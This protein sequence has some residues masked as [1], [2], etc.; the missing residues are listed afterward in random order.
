MNG[1]TRATLSNDETGI[2]H[3]GKVVWEFVGVQSYT[4]WHQA[5]SREIENTW[6]CI[7]FCRT[8]G[9]VKRVQE[10]SEHSVHIRKKYVVV[11]SMTLC[12]LGAVWYANTLQFWKWSP[13]KETAEVIVLNQCI[14]A[15][16]ATG[17]WVARTKSYLYIMI[18]CILFCVHSSSHYLREWI[19]LYEVST[20]SMNVWFMHRWVAP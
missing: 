1:W 6:L 8:L 16:S 3:I 11:I 20:S 19:N 13:R 7:N 9:T 18:F 5:W 15:C 14:P 10:V 4:A 12:L 2:L 17:N